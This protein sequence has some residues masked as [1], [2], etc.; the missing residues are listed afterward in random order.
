MSR[1]VEEEGAGEL[2]P[3]ATN[4]R[5]CRPLLSID[6]LEVNDINNANQKILNFLFQV[7]ENLYWTTLS[8]S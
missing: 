6:I 8:V 3:L 4:R 5:G 2:S 7:L 1:G